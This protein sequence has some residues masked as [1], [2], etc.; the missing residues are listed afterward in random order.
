MGKKKGSSMFSPY[1][2]NII[3]ALASGRTVKAIFREIIYPALNGGC[4]YCGMLYYINH[5]GVR[6]E[7]E[8]DGYEIVPNCRECENRCIV[9]MCNEKQKDKFFCS[10]SGDSKRKYQEIENH[11]LHSPRWCPKRDPKRQGEI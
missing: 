6:Q 10:I 1:R 7:A 4:T 5:T 3:D 2:Q 11:I 9:K 8:K